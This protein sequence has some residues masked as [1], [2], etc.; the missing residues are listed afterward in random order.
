MDPLGL[1]RS[2]GVAA[3]RL[4]VGLLGVGARDARVDLEWDLGAV[5]LDGGPAN[6]EPGICSG[7]TWTWRATNST[8]SPARLTVAVWEAAVAGIELQ[9]QR[10]R[11]PAG[12]ALPRDQLVIPLEQRPVLDQLVQVERAQW[13]SRKAPTAVRNGTSASVEP[14]SEPIMSP[15]K[16]WAP[17]VPIPQAETELAHCGSGRVAGPAAKYGLLPLRGSSAT[18]MRRARVAAAA[19]QDRQRRAASAFGAKAIA[20]RD[21]G[22]VR[23][24]R[25]L[26][27]LSASQLGTPAGDECDRADCA[28]GSP[29]CR[30]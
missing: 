28:R 7:G 16:T 17:E 26:R 22:R 11:Q 1:P 20:G 18:A 30:R 8:T 19:A 15:Q 14:S 3:D 10:E 2:H 29:G 24:G 12:A 9:H 13:S 23:P 27:R 21:A 4:I 25:P 6:S 5:V